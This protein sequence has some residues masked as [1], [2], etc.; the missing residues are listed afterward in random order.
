MLKAVA[1]MLFTPNRQDFSLLNNEALAELASQSAKAREELVTRLSDDVLYFIQSQLHSVEHG[2]YAKR[3]RALDLLHDVW[4]TWLSKPHAFKV[5]TQGSF[6]AWLF[7]IARNKLIDELRKGRKQLPWQECEHEPQLHVADDYVTTLIN[8]ASQQQL[9][10]A[11]AA[12]PYLQRESL[13][14]Q[15]EGF[16][17]HEI[18]MITNS[19]KESVKTRL[20]Y[21]KANIAQSINKGHGDD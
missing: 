11:I 2:N 17:L 7:A 8:S 12:L 4:L 13:T 9:S 21:G 19:E 6:K 14:L 18:A 20:R 5:Q 10:S 16:S 15:L 3:Q 1:S